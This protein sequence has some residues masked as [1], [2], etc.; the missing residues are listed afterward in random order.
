MANQFAEFTALNAA[1]DYMGNG[2]II[3]PITILL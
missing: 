2:A 1:A 3:V